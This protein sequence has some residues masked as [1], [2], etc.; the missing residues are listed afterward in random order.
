MKIFL[1]L[2]VVF[3]MIG[4]LVNYM[5]NDMNGILVNGFGAMAL[6]TMSNDF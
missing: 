5:Q 1:R 2:I 3:N 6:A 4:I